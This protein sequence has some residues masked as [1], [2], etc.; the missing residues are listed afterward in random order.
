M[1]THNANYEDDLKAAENER[2]NQEERLKER[3]LR[4]QKKKQEEFIDEREQLEAEVDDEEVD[5]L[6]IEE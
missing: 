4:R 2:K 6:I 3:M 1:G 5:P